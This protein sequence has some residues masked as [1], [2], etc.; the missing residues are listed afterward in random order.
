MFVE[1]SLPAEKFI[2]FESDLCWGDNR[3]YPQA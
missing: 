1:N 3:F 2:E